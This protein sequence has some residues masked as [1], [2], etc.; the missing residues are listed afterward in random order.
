MAT[1][2]GAFATWSANTS[3]TERVTGAFEAAV[4]QDRSSSS[5]PGG[6]A[7]T[8]RPSGS[9]AIASTTERYMPASRSAAARPS[10]P[11]CVTRLRLPP[12]VVTISE[13]S[14]EPSPVLAPMS[15]RSVSTCL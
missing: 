14:V 15:T 12:S 10:T 5:S 3:S 2:S 1:A 6:S 13:N 9:A 11:V 4:P 7:A 8:A